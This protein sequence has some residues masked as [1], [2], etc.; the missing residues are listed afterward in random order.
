MKNNNRNDIKNISN[1]AFIVKWKK[2]MI[3]GGEDP[4]CLITSVEIGK[5]IQDIIARNKG[6]IESIEQYHVSVVLH[7]EKE[8]IT[9][10][11]DSGR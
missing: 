10:V 4:N 8:S 3:H 9:L 5:S 2:T 1:K 7:D 11:Y 6:K